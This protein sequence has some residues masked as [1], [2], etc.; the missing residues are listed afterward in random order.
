MNNL[1]TF[2]HPE[3]GSFRATNGDTPLFVAKDIAELLGY[4]N[5]SAAVMKHVDDEDRQSVMIDNSTGKTKTTLINESGFYSLIFNSK[6]PKAKQVQRWIMDELKEYR[7]THR[8]IPYS[9]AEFGDISAFFH[10]NGDISLCLDDVAR[11]L[12]F[13]QKDLKNG[14]EYQNIRWQRIKQYCSEFG[15]EYLVPYEGLF[16]LSRNGSFDQK[17][18][19]TTGG[20][21]I[22]EGLFYLL[23][24][25]SNSQSAKR[26]QEWVALE[27]VPAIRKNGFYAKGDATNKALMEAVSIIKAQ[28]KLIMESNNQMGM[29]KAQYARLTDSMADINI[30]LDALGN[31]GNRQID[32]LSAL[33]S[34]DSAPEAVAEVA[35]TT[36]TNIPEFAAE[37]LGVRASAKELGM[38]QRE[39]VTWMISHG[40]FI[41]NRYG[42]LCLTDRYA[43]CERSFQVSHFK[44]WYMEEPAVSVKITASGRKVIWNAIQSERSA[45]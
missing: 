5:P 42:D 11:G 2:T 13:I 37:P 40:V 9:N 30:R 43:D 16:V 34:H 12:G 10:N 25:K 17:W 22:P 6:L 24:M 28:N 4:T 1:T 32:L 21:F 7:K 8:I 38:K 19:K 45:A 3:L 23:A 18:S 33:V 31:M 26:F 36:N 39:F 35:V 15:F 44:R 41:R 14:V 27:V 20:C 29:L